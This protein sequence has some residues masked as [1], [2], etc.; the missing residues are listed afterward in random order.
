MCE[1]PETVRSK[2]SQVFVAHR[3]TAN[4]GSHVPISFLL[5]TA[6]VVPNFRETRLALNLRQGT[7][8]EPAPEP[9]ASM[10]QWKMSCQ[11]GIIRWE[12][13]RY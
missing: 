11:V 13:G 10:T 5:E 12:L 1:V 7:P 3:L 2:T 8:C 4:S 9:K 6:N